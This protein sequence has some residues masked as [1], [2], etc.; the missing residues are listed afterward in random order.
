MSQPAVQ[1]SALNGWVDI[2]AAVCPDP[3]EALASLGFASDLAAKNLVAASGERISLSA[4]A[5]MAE[6]VGE[7]ARNP[8]TTWMLGFNYDLLELGEVGRAILGAKTLGGAMRR[9]SEHFELL[10]D[11][12]A[13]DFLV[14]S[15]FATINYRILDPEIWPRHHD[16]LFSLGI[17][18]RIISLAVPDALREMEIGFE[19]GKRDTGLAVAASQ[20]SFGGETNSISMPLAM[21]DAPMPATTS[22]C[23]LKSLSFALAQKRRKEPTRNRLEAIIFARLAQGEVNQDMLASEIGMSSRTM[24]RRLA[25]ADL[26]FQ[27]LLDECR[28][29]QAVLEFKARPE[30]S[31]AQVALRLGYAEH[32]NF[33]RA[34][35]RWVGM[36][37][38]RFRSQIAQSTH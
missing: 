31:I 19:S 20:L 22:P 32:S 21:L 15:D 25:E 13:L 6:F 10:Q 9:F 28:M 27:Q 5:R 4:F 18:A 8:A 35:T 7:R 14:A 26:T 30:A 34:F 3:A 29:Q 12:T 24:R 33:T 17:V 2:L 23:N 37:P 16:A 1:A 36:P 38:Q 11:R